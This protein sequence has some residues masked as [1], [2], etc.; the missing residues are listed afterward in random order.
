MKKLTHNGMRRLVLSTVIVITFVIGFMIRGITEHDLMNRVSIY[1]LKSDGRIEECRYYILGAS[2]TNGTIALDVSQ[3]AFM[4]DGLR[5]D[6]FRLDITSHKATVTWTQE[7]TQF[8]DTFE[9]PAYISIVDA[10]SATYWFEG[11]LKRIYPLNADGPPVTTEQINV[12]GKYKESSGMSP[13]LWKVMSL[14]E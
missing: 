2:V 6:Q 1:D 9:G 12:R 5:F 8:T 7:P 3:K 13:L 4:R 14:I 11:T 10:D